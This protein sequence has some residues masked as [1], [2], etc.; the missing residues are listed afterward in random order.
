LSLGFEFSEAEMQRKR[1][2]RGIASIDYTLT[3]GVVLPMAAVA[4]WFGPRIMKLV[5]EFTSVIVGWPF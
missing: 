5:Y 3:I 2:R 1:S 4:L